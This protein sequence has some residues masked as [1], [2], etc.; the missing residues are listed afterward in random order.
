MR[1]MRQRRIQSARTKRKAGAMIEPLESR[2]LLAAAVGPAAPGWAGF[3]GDAQHTADSAHAS[4]ALE[5]IHWQTK[6]DLNP[7]LNGG[8]L[9][10]HYGSPVITAKNT[11]IVPVK[12]GADGGFRLEAHDGASGKLKWTLTTDYVLPPHVFVPSYSP[13][14]APDG[15]LYF[16]GAGGTVYYVDN[17]DQSSTPEVHQIAFY[18]LAKYSANKAAFNSTVFIDT[19]ITA[20]ITRDIFFGFQVTGDNPLHL[21]GGLAKI[22]SSGAGKY[23]SAAVATGD[24]GVDKVMQNCAPALSRFNNFVYVAMDHTVKLGVGA[25]IRTGTYLL[26]IDTHTMTTHAMVR[27]T[28]PQSGLDIQPMDSA[29]SSPTIGP[30]G[31][32]F[33]GILDNPQDSNHDRGWLMHF[34]WDLKQTKTTGDFGWDD[35][36]S[37]VPASMVKSYHG[38]SSYLLMTKYNNYADH[39]GNGVNKIAVLDPNAVEIDASTGQTVMKEVLTIAGVTPD[40]DHTQQFP[41][42][43]KEW[44]INSA[45]VD[46]ATDSVLVNS[47]D[48]KLYRWN[49]GQNQFTQVVKL[50]NGLDEAYTPTVV[51]P[52][53]TVYAINDATLFAVGKKRG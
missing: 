21:A 49:V 53:G 27:L 29:T 8:E 14:L 36:A 41:K 23:L 15:R 37:I 43:V 48:G 33:C 1:K 45:A 35:T 19:P 4:Q 26:M 40:T 7:Q 9:I 12:T 18:G 31:D 44:C 2:R 46:P 3:A 6:V 42:A 50:T 30:N 11:V 52:D 16:A 51:G 28:D 22:T 39:G 13:V 5:M 47:E 34:S 20:G 24:A 17:P 38:K 32:I 10:A 25:G